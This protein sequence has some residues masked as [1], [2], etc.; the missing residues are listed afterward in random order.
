MKRSTRRLLCL[1][2]IPA[3]LF[4]ADFA[5]R[6]W[7][8]PNASLLS[9]VEFYRLFIPI[10]ALIAAVVGVL[11][12]LLAQLVALI[13]RR[14]NERKA[15]CFLLPTLVVF[16]LY[17]ALLLWG[18]IGFAA[19]TRGL[20]RME[21]IWEAENPQTA[22]DV[23]RIFGEPDQTEPFRARNSE[24]RWLYH[25]LPFVCAP[26]ATPYQVWLDADGN[27]VGHGHRGD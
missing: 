16:S 14:R 4:A 9:H 1:F 24:T 6:I 2:A 25:P 22:D 7:R 10:G 27:I 3:A 11:R 13:P 12:L 8:F 5:V 15:A 18:D 19:E 21:R 20:E 26:L 17:A 23:R